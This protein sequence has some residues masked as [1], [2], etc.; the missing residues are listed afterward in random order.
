MSNNLKNI[1]NKKTYEG[2]INIFKESN[3][4]SNQANNITVYN[5]GKNKYAIKDFKNLKVLYIKYNDEELLKKI[6]LK[7]NSFNRHPLILY[8]FNILYICFRENEFH[9]FDDVIKDLK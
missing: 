7:I 1:E 6:V 8:K 3:K 5:S 9:I 4:F 2:T